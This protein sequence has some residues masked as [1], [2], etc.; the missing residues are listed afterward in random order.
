[1]DFHSNTFRW[2]QVLA[3]FNFYLSLPLNSKY[4]AVSETTRQYHWMRVE[5]CKR[6]LFISPFKKKVNIFLKST[7]RQP[8]RKCNISISMHQPTEPKFIWVVRYHADYELT[9]IHLSISPSLAKGRQWASNA[10]EWPVSHVHI[11]H[12]LDSNSLAFRM[13]K[14][15]LSGS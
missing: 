6:E 9:A 13:P 8:Q 3:N 7:K 11:H 4:K 2:R 5:T 10:W 1:M 12:T 14:N 15:D